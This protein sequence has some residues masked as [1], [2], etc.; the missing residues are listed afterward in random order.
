[1]VEWRILI[2]RFVKFLP[3][4]FNKLEVSDMSDYPYNYPGYP[5]GLEYPWTFP[6]P[7]EK[8]RD[9]RWAAIIKAL[10]T[11]NLDCLIIGAVS[12]YISFPNNYIHYVSNYV[13][14]F[15]PG[16][17]IVFPRQGTPQLDLNKSLGPQFLHFASATSWIREITN[18]LNPAEDMIHKIKNLGL[19]KG[20]LGIVGYNNGTFPAVIH[21]A[22]RKNLPEARFEDATTILINTMSEVSRTSEE[23][24]KFL[25]KAC[26]IHDLSFKA[27]TK[28]LK[29]GVTEKKLWAAA[30]EVILSHGG[31]FPHF[32]LVTSG[33]KPTFVR[34]PASDYKIKSGDIVM[35]ETNVIYGGVLAQIAYT[36]SLGK[37][38][39]QI[40][41]MFNFCSELYDFAIKELEKKRTF[42]DIEQ[43]LVDQIHRAGYEPMTPQM[44]IYNASGSMPANSPPYPGDY[45]TIHP[46]FATRDF[47]AGAKFGDSVRINRDGKVERLQKT[48]AKLNIINP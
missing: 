21:D 2:S 18:S 40:E 24:F 32:M 38:E 33:P 42:G 29:P 28:A 37:P 25:K 8:E 26:E 31:W 43:D 44:H 46:N 4:G 14:V 30:E 20:R 12:G 39:K 7:S 23:E 1:M 10:E 27:V 36:L 16:T 19:E 45:F 48:P 13:P 5:A 34:A 6:A 11:H 22:L 17:Y 41:K 47:T 3:S 15:N 9:K 35:F